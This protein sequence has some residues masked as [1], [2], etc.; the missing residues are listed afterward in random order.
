LR[1]I[2]L[3]ILF[4]FEGG[5]FLLIYIVEEKRKIF[6]LIKSMLKNEEKYIFLDGHAEFSADFKKYVNYAGVLICKSV[7]PENKDCV[8][9]VSNK[10]D[11]VVCGDFNDNIDGINFGKVKTFLINIENIEKYRNINFGNSQII[12]CGLRE[13]DTVIFSSIDMDEGS[14]ILDLQRNIINIHEEKIEPFEK[15]ITLDCSINSEDTENILLALSVLLYCGRL[16]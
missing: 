6:D 3:N 5:I 10:V 7:K 11:L 9:M 13:K 15:K 12:T 16:K 2:K 4:Y 8:N 14:V 1:I